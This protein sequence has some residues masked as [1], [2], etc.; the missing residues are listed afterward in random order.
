MLRTRE[1]EVVAARVGDLWISVQPDRPI[2]DAAWRAHLD[3]SVEEV[4]RNGPY[5]GLLVWAPKHGPSAHQRRIMTDE[6]RKPLRLDQQR[7]CA[8]ITES[9]IVRGILTAF[10]WLG[11]GTAMNAFAPPDAAKAFDWLALHVSFDRK[12]AEDAL[13]TLRFSNVRPQRAGS[14]S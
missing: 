13:H 10:S 5:P 7:A 6:Y 1:G 12:Q 3:F 14:A 8:V 4:A 2:D 11:S 9:A